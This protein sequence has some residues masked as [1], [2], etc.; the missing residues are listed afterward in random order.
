MKNENYQD[1]EIELDVNYFDTKEDL[2]IQNLSEIMLF[3]EC[4]KNEII[5]LSDVFCLL[6]SYFP[7]TFNRIKEIIKSKIIKTEISKRNPS[8]KKQVN[9][10]FY[11]LM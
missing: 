1:N 11:L 5:I 8:Y 9:E 10:V 7:N 3:L 4:Y 2:N 6:S